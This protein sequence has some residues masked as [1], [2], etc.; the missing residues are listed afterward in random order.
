MSHFKNKQ[1]FTLIEVLVSASILAIGIASILEIFSAGIKFS[2][3]AKNGAIA[4]GILQETM[5]AAISLGYDGAIAGKGERIK[6]SSDLSN[7]LYIFETQIEISFVNQDLNESADDIGMKKIKASVF[8]KES[9]S[10]KEETAV[11]L[12]AKS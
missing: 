3:Y 7:P 1:S 11:V 4:A 12:I 5:E 10:E 9:G 8:W 2:R 6:F